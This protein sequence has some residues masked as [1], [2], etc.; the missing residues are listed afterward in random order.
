MFY[1]KYIA[2]IAELN[3]I[4]EDDIDGVYLVISSTVRHN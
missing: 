2:G 1:F 3:D 4:D